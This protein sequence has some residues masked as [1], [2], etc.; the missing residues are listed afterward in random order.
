[1]DLTEI[2]TGAVHDAE[3][4]IIDPTTTTID[5]ND[6]STE[7][8]EPVEAAASETPEPAAEAPKK[9]VAKK[10]TA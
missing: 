10:A 8:P 9:R 3:D 1:M 4:G 7:S 5:P 2:I 6:I